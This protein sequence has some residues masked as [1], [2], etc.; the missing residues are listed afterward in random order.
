MSNNL[1]TLFSLERYQEHY[2]SGFWRDETIYALVKAHAE[3]APD[4][5]A[6]RSRNGDLSYRALLAHVDAFASDLAEKG[7]SVG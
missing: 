6:I 4:R 1:L 7:V 5:I 2:R 3:R